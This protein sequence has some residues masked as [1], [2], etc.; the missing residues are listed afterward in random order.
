M[1]IVIDAFGGDNAPDAII[2][3][4]V[5]A[6]KRSQGFDL[7]L[8]G[9]EAVLKQKLSGCEYDSK[10]VE[11]RH[12]PDV[13]T[14]HDAPVK[15]VRQKTESSLVVALNTVAKKE[16]DVFISAGSTGAVLAG[17]TLIVRRIKGIKRPALAPVLPSKTGSGVLLID[18][19]ANVDCKPSYLQQFGIMG[20]IYMKTVFGV[21]NPRVGLLNNGAEEEKG[22]AVAAAA[23]QLLKQTPVNFVGNIEGREMLSGNVDVAVADGF[24]GN[25]VLKF[26]EGFASTLFSM[27]K[28]EFMSSFRSKLGAM[29]LKPSLYNFKKKMDYTEYGGALLLGIDGGIIKAHGSSNAKAIASTILQAKKFGDNDVVGKIKAEISSLSFEDEA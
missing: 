21:Q 26:M 25:V 15:A 18:C 8:V 29:L 4:S 14:M 9:D 13:I 1:K 16:A 6:L 28:D 19:G 3:G 27:L 24:V 20:S 7:I 12:A 11:I 10:R 22:N 17:A 5:E 23:H 2:A